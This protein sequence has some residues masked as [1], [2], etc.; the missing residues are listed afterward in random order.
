MYALDT[1]AAREADQFGAYLNE[2]GKYKGQFTRAEKLVSKQKG[3]HGVGF[4]FEAEDKRTTRF[5][6]WT[7][8]GAGDHL[9]GYKF[10]NALLACMKLRQVTEAPAKVD[11]YNWDTKQ[12][13][14][15]DATVF[16]ELIGKPVGLVLRNTEYEKMRDGMLTGETGWRLE[17]LVP[18]EAATEFTSSEIL[19]RKTKPEKLASVM[20]TVTDRP[21]KKGPAPAARQAQDRHSPQQASQGSGFDDMGDD[22]PW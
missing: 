15:V 21:L 22:I 13:E 4:T 8:N 2:T 14:K 18:F 16:P 5:D 10:V 20:A 19:D 7:I 1:Q 11:R 6:V 9:P 17:P 12:I 3:T